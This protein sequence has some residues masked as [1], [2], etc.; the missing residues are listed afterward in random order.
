MSR[1]AILLQWKT[2]DYINCIDYYHILIENITGSFSLP[3]QIVSITHNQFE[4][5]D[6][7]IGK[8]YSVIISGA[9]NATRGEW[10]NR[11]IYFDGEQLPYS[12]PLCA[13]TL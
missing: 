6:L 10:T 3:I 7:V 5:K 13:W 1:T 9:N 12:K 4:V 2:P 8:N 11:T